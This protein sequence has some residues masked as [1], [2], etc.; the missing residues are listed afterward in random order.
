ML[1]LKSP[2]D[3]AKEI[4]NI[5]AVWSEGRFLVLRR[6]VWTAIPRQSFFSMQLLPQAITA[7]RSSVIC[8]DADG[9]FTISECFLGQPG[10][11]KHFCT[12][13][14]TKPTTPQKQACSGQNANHCASRCHLT[15]RSFVQ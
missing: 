9:C 15:D 13:R 12:C 11:R 14:S 2:V 1:D 3:M 5:P 8:V 6:G 4:E 7:V 10:L